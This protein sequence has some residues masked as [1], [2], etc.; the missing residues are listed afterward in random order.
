MF[1]LLVVEHSFLVPH[2]FIVHQPVDSAKA[3]SAAAKSDAIWY[4]K[5]EVSAPSRRDG[6]SSEEN[7]S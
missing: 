7:G 1:T 5:P 3:I 6:D 2:I 4:L